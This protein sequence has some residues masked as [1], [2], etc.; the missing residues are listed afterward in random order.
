MTLFADR[1]HLLDT[2][3]AFKIGPQIA[4]I[5]SQGH[6]VVKLNLGEPDFDIPQFIKEEIKRRIDENL[7]HYCDPSGILPLREAIANQLSETRGISI[8]ADKIVVFPGAKPSIG[9]TQEAYVNPGEEVIYPSP[10]FPIYESF[11][12][13]IGA[14]PKPLLLKD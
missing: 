14:V 11:I 2:E 10:G 9:F 13:Y 5:E 3:N 8:T 4:K 7:T 12:R 1:T 6:K